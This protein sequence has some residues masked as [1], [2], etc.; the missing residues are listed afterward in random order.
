MLHYRNLELYDLLG[1]NMAEY[2]NDIFTTKE[3]EKQI[4]NREWKV[5]CFGLSLGL[6]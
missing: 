4:Q 2:M 3:C 6:V 1:D 5:K